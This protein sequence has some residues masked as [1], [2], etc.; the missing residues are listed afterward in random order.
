MIKNS[1]GYS[2][3]E[4]VVVIAIMGLLSV[5]VAA[6]FISTARGGGRSG[7]LAKV[8]EEGD[9]AIATIERNLRYAKDFDASQCIS[10]LI[11]Y[12]D[13]DGVSYEYDFGIDR[14]KRVKIG[15][16]GNPDQEDYLTSAAMVVDNVDLVCMEADV[17]KSAQVSVSFDLGLVGSNNKETF[18]TK[19]TLR[20]QN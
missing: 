3:I 9:F 13:V 16:G 11:S 7:E 18:S 19:V 20:N 4:L 15:V 2:L 8:K 5:G 17:G 1:F 6:T 10:K 14:I 12:K